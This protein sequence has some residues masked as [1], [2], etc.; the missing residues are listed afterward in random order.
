MP[1]H[2][3]DRVSVIRL[4]SFRMPASDRG[5]GS[6]AVE[7]ELAQ[8][9]RHHEIY[10]PDASVLGIGQGPISFQRNHPRRNHHPCIRFR[11]IGPRPS[12]YQQ[13]HHV[14]PTL[15]RACNRHSTPDTRRL[16]PRRRC[17]TSDRAGTEILSRK[18]GTGSCTAPG[19]RHRYACTDTPGAARTTARERS[20]RPPHRCTQ[21][22][23]RRMS[24]RPRHAR[25][26]RS[27]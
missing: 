12:R 19:Y 13:T 24:C 20:P 27:R 2:Y 14:S 7:P 17:R 26:A 16:M 1:R 10:I 8:R 4:V 22:R 5:A 18:F 6:K 21:W 15:A 25:T 11:C 23:S 9:A 3:Y